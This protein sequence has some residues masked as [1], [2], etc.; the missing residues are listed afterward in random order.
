MNRLPIPARRWI[1]GLWFRALRRV[2]VDPP[3]TRRTSFSPSPSGAFLTQPRSLDSAQDDVSLDFARDGVSLDCVPKKPA[4]ASTALT[5]SLLFVRSRL[6]RPRQRRA[7]S[8]NDGFCGAGS[9]DG[10]AALAAQM[11]ALAEVSEG[12]RQAR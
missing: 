11:R 1:Y 4:I 6:L 12:R 2:A 9:P 3:R 10:P 8:R 5:R 7:R